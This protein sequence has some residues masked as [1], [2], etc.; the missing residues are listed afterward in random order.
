M[1]RIAFMLG[2]LLVTTSYPASHA[3]N[4]PKSAEILNNFDKERYYPSNT[5]AKLMDSYKQRLKRSQKAGQENAPTAR[6]VIDQP[7]VPGS[8]GVVSKN[9]DASD[10]TV[11]INGDTQKAEKEIIETVSERSKSSSLQKKKYSYEEQE[12]YLNSKLTRRMGS[13]RADHD[14]SDLESVVS[15]VHVV[16]E[17]F[18]LFDT[19]ERKVDMD[20]IVKNLSKVDTRAIITD[21]KKMVEQGRELPVLRAVQREVGKELLTHG[22]EDVKRDGFKTKMAMQK[23]H[24]YVRNRYSKARNKQQREELSRIS[25]ML[26]LHMSK[27]I[28]MKVVRLT[29][30]PFVFGKEV[31]KVQPKIITDFIETTDDYEPY[32]EPVYADVRDAE[33]LEEMMKKYN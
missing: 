28:P 8:G 15:Y 24:N 21:T 12:A 16:T 19:S 3:Q 27:D 26:E 33:L 25:D 14:L 30:N 6:P 7:I 10:L 1:R 32:T 9:S 13:L 29:L 5:G 18:K 23:L 2:F 17:A 20:G 11:S 31:E 4:H 22:L